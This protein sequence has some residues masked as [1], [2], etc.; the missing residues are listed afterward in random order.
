MISTSM[1]RRGFVKGAAGVAV[2]AMAGEQLAM[3]EAPSPSAKRPNIVFVLTDQWRAQA[4]GY[5]KQDPV[6]TPRLDAFHKEATTFTQAIAS[7]P[8][9][10]PNRA[11]LFTGRFPQNHGVIQ[12][13]RAAVQPEQ[14]L[15]RVF[16][17]N[18]Y[19]NGYI[20]K[21]H[22][23][24]ADAHPVHQGIT[25]APMRADYED[26]TSAIHNHAHFGL[27]FDEQGERVDYG[28]GWQPDHVTKK[29]IAFMEQEDDR[30]FHLVVSY[31]PP[32]NGN[33]HPD[34]CAEKRYT[35]GDLSHKENGYGYY[36]P[37]E[38]EA[39]Y[40]QLTPSDI[41]AN[42]E[43]IPQKGGDGF[44]TIA[45]AIA[46][47]YGACTALDAS[48]GQ[49]IDYLKRTGRY[50]N[51]IVVFT[52]DHGEMMGSHGLMT[53]GVCFEESINV[54]L[55][56]RVPGVAASTSD[57]LFN[58]VDLMPTLMGLSGLDIPA[59]V[60]GRDFTD[61][62]AEDPATHTPDK[63]L[64]GYAQFRGWRTPT[65]TYVT[66]THE[67]G[68]LV[69]R[70]AVYLRNK[71]QTRSSHILF[72]LMNDPYQQRPILRGDATSTDSVIDDLHR[73]LHFELQLRGEV[74]SER[75]G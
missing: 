34:F 35:P 33:Y 27:A 66:T 73:S 5:A 37:A 71:R 61:H 24:G 16:K 42:V 19:Q 69:G 36:A 13:N 41:R 75:V 57:L 7:S 23:N 44:D 9:C 48:F 67:S 28:F 21:W 32:H 25:P 4:M 54:P 46:G 2:S 29:A 8:V 22:L 47:Y 56:I 40:H 14:L 50:E 12:N 11:C 38:Y 70:E 60:D 55:M 62:F 3:G 17:A 74:I 6:S 49:L 15:S 53:K 64:I 52:S 58:S 10:S 26:W 1:S 65:Y 45:T 43:P 51:T 20:G 72:D 30:P 39:P 68:H 59:G 18:G 31:S 63:A